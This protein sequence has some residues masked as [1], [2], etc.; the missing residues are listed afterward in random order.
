M[1]L[2][3]TIVRSIRLSLLLLAGV[4][5]AAPD[6]PA[7]EPL[8]IV[9]FRRETHERAVHLVVACSGPVEFN[10]QSSAPSRLRLELLSVE[11][12]AIPSPAQA[13]SNEAE[14]VTLTLS[15]N[16][17]VYLDLQLRQFTPHRVR[18]RSNEVV[19]VLNPQSLA[20]VSS[21]SLPQR[22]GTH[23]AKAQ[24]RVSA[25]QAAGDSAPEPTVPTPV[26]T[27]VP[28]LVPAPAPTPE[29]AD[30]TAADPDPAR[31]AS[32]SPHATRVFEA[33]RGRSGDAF[34]IHIAT[35]GAPQ[36]SA[37][38]TNDRPHRLVLD[39]KGAQSR[40]LFSRLEV[41]VGPIQH[42]RIAQHT[43]DPNPVVRIVFD[44]NERIAHR[45]ESGPDGVMVIFPGVVASVQ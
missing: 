9:G 42:V 34:A 16:G 26:P 28:T 45:I 39:V 43:G 32:D 38:F 12:T 41:G 23:E 17:S 21:R 33:S 27:P 5:L 11:A 2:S 19:I 10:Y 44:L 15:P 25:V 36:Y 29:P 3:R 18:S 35:N 1:T 24:D 8:R 4:V 37:F 13:W 31:F 7:T 20:Q 6:A 22:P 30:T 40:P 14:S